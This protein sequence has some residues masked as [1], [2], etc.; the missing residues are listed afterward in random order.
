M[1]KIS[2]FF[3]AML[4]A[5]C[6]NSDD[7]TIDCSTVLCAAAFNT[8]DI[9]LYNSDGSENL[10]DNGTISGSSIVITD[11]SNT[12]VEHSI[13]GPTNLGNYISIPVATDRYGQKS[14]AVNFEGGNPFT[15]S[16]TTSLTDDFECCGPYTA[17]DN[18]TISD[19]ELKPTVS[20]FLP[21]NLTIYID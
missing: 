3:I 16:F 15:L 19:Y 9:Y 20:E 10:L 14:F 13:E 7:D 6:F 11:E 1:K 18:I 8:L 2:L 4:F 17:L 21:L 12:T 5:A